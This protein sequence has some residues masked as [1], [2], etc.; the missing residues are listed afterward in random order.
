VR[1]DASLL[2]SPLAAAAPLARSHEAA[3]YDGAFTF[4]GPNEPFASLVLAAEH[5]KLDLATGV[6]IAFARSPMTVA[7]A[8]H[9]LHTFSGG[10]FSLGLGSQVRAH[11][12]RRFSMPWSRP[13]SR[14]KEYV[15]ALRAIFACWNDDEPLSFEGEFYRHTMM[16]PLMRPSPCPFGAPPILLAAVGRP[17]LE[18]AGE[19]ADGCVL[20]PFHSRSYLDGFALPA[21]QAGR[22]RSSRPAFAITAQV[23][24]VTGANDQETAAAREAVRAQVAFY[25]STPAY[26]PVL[27]AEDEGD[28]QPELRRLTKE[29]RWSEMG[30]L[31]TDELVSRI[32][33][34]GSPR[35]AGRELV[36]RYAGLASRV[37]IATPML[38][39]DAASRE[40][41][42]GFRD[43]TPASP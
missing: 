3:G 32:A 36:R 23:L 42:A 9:D 5:T 39:S 27:E 22:A 6:A 4:D 28:L 20:H 18:A 33:V 11:V 14:M 13:V 7:Q 38:L 1:I 8:A 30:A 16:P 15:A 2:G 12:E 43:A 35:E 19:A 21:I 10:R 17:M 31:V 37:A 25:G 24:V 34:V 26:R 29:G 40:L 41:V